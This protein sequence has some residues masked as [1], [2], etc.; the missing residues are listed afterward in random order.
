MIVATAGHVD[1]GKTLLVKMLTGMD[2]DRL[3]EEK[4]RGL[5]INVGF[6]Y[7][8]IDAT[9]TL[10]FIDVP[11]HMRFI[12]NMIAGING[13]DVGMLVVAAD[14]GP[15]PQ[16]REHMDVLRLLGVTR[17][18]LVISKIDR[19]DKA[20]VNS[21]REAALALFPEPAEVPVFEVASL[22]GRGIGELDQFLQEKAT[23][24]KPKTSSGYFRLS[25]DRAFLMKGSGLVVTGTVASGSVQVGESLTLL[26]QN[27]SV[28]I[29]SLQIQEQQQQQAFTGQ[30]CALNIS[31][32]IEKDDIERGDWLV[33][34]HASQATTRFDARL[35]LL[36]H[37]PLALKHMSPVKLY[38]GAKRIPAR[39]ALL[40]Q[41]TISSGQACYAQLIVKRALH[42]CHG[43]RFLL[44]DDSENETLG[45]GIVLDPR[46]LSSGRATKLRL[47]LLEVMEQATAGQVVGSL[48]FELKQMLNLPHFCLSWNI[49]ADEEA[50]LLG[51]ARFGD[52][53]K[54]ISIQDTQFVVASANWKQMIEWVH[55]E[56][57][58]VAK[59]AAGVKPEKLKSNF[60][61]RFAGIDAGLVLMHMQ[62]AGSITVGLDRIAL[63]KQQQ[64][65]SEEQLGLWTAME[66]YLRQC[67][68]NVPVPADMAQAI[69]RDQKSI[70]ELAKLATKEKWLVK[71]VDNRLALAEQVIQ[72]AELAQLLVNRQKSFSVAEFKNECGI[73]RN[74]AV[75]VLEYFDKIGFTLRKESGRV[76][77]NHDRVNTMLS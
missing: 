29:R 58:S 61:K 75:D 52:K 55:N 74:L 49:R 45:G 27:I 28:R 17:F 59:G 68:L 11:G 6:A 76:I 23:S 43:D 12:N 46:A 39:L 53:V 60:N 7:R 37:T 2:T 9:K 24:L 20:R 54:V 47:A 33:D 71:I 3:E 66:T 5:S 48:L 70:L 32:D 8:K 73:G 64:D 72:F 41:K 10:V 25:V 63:C 22:E 15:M 65:L 62:S 56:L 51:L 13:I 69:G 38:I 36:K 26:P 44:R 35:R 57:V 21:V 16:T 42:C 14:D 19:V 50:A 40:G 31:G 67:G 30:R 4:R 34:A 77:L 18:V 1:H